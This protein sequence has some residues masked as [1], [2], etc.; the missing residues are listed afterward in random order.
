MLSEKEQAIVRA[1]QNDLPLVKEPYKEVAASIGMSEEELLEGIRAL[2]EKGCLKRM[3]IA[4]RHNNVGYTINVM[5]VWDVNPADIERLGKKMA[6]HPKVTHCYERKKDPEFDYNL[7][8]M[9]HAQSEE[10]YQALLQELYDIA[11][12]IK[13]MELRTIRELKK[14]GMKYF[15]GN[16]LAGLAQG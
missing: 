16:E 1:L 5:T 14:I 10:E 3:S 12:P 15:M 4:L 8:A 6:A 9:V 7:Y 2:Q 11:Q 13:Y